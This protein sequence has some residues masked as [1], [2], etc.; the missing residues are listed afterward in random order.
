MRITFQPARQSRSGFALVVVLTFLVVSLVV[1]ASV[2]YWASSNSKITQRN[3]VFT[4]AQSAAESCCEYIIS[5]MIRDFN[6]LCLNTSNSYNI[7]A[8]PT[9]GWPYAY[10]FAATNGASGLTAFVSIGPTNWGAVPSQFAGLNGLGQNCVIA[11]T[12]TPLNQPVNVPATVVESI[13]FGTIP[14]FQYAVFYNVALE[15]NPGGA[16]TISGRVHCNTNIYCTG[17]SSSQPLTFLNTVDAAGIIT[18]RSSPLDPRSPIRTGNVVF[19]AGSPIQNYDTLNLPLGTSTTNYTFDAIEALLRIPPAAYA[20]GTADAYSTNGQAYFA[21]RADLIITNDPVTGTNI[22][23]LYQNANNGPNYLIPVPPDAIGNIQTNKVITTNGTIVKTYVTNYIYTT[24]F[25]YSYVTNDYFYD[26]RETATVSA[27]QI[28]VSKLTA[29]LANTNPVRGGQQFEQL[30]AS[31]TTDKGSVINSIYVYNSLP[32]KSTNVPAVRLVNAQQLPTNSYGTYQSSGLGVATA[33]PIYVLGNYN[34]TRDFVNFAYSL[35][36]TTNGSTVPACLLGDAITILSSNF[37]DNPAGGTMNPT[38]GQNTITLN[39]ACFEGIVQSD[40]THYSGGLENFLRLLENWNSKTVV[41]NGS[42][43]VMFPSYFG[44]NFYNGS[45][46]GV[47]GTRA[48]GFDV[49]FTQA[50]KLP[51]LCPTIKANA[52]AAWSYGQQ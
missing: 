15:I 27:L 29:W 17:N 6:T 38:P 20:P 33:Q 32:L 30:N 13:W 11:C 5:S 23:V 45:V 42:I 51:P 9:N 50:G 36:S 26:Y 47:P 8:P 12:A 14:V 10:Q 49:T 16:M 3:I 37:V 25:Y 24:N 34:V 52:R 19:P 35:G 1:F 40:G 44:T 2:M 46:Y 48:W 22:T 28:D 4:Q 21:N 43:V 18:N 7:L 39:A 41:Y 31:S